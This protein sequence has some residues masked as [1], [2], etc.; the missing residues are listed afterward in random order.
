MTY[1]ECCPACRS[2]DLEVMLDMGEQPMSLVSLQED[3]M[4]SW[5]LER[6]RIRLAIC[7]NCSHVHNIDFNPNYVSYSAAGC[8]MF[9]NGAGWQQHVEDVR[10]IIKNLP[11]INAIV[12]IGAGDCEFLASLETEAA[13]IAV[14]PCEAV[15]RAEELGITRWH[16][17]HFDPSVHIPMDGNIV[18]LMR[19]LLEHMEDPRSFVEKIVRVAEKR[20]G[21]TYLM[22]ECPCC[23]EALKQLRIED[24]TYE[25]PQHFTV[26]SMMYMLRA[27]GI[28]ICQATTHYDME[29]LIGL[30]KIEPKKVHSPTT[31]Q[32]LFGYKRLE[33]NIAKESEWVRLMDERVALWG[34]AGKSAMFI[35]KFDLLETVRVVDSHEEKWGF[36]VPGTKI[37]MESPA[38]LIEDPVDCII[39]TTSWRA[40]DIR[41]EI[42]GSGIPCKHLMKFERGKL[43]EVP[44]EE[45]TN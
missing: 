34:G 1:I 17:E 44:L 12:E 9:N 41:E 30:A 6:H 21:N 33:K 37:V 13:T 15:E 38:T 36:C 14:D 42:L 10:G 7:R 2:T 35:N 31:E 40:N 20:T 26:I 27:C 32:I 23:Q 5:A 45:T 43:V 19:H 24:W 8:R 25:H 3:P 11:E 16:R 22:M 18:I 28:K 4:N 39:V 29:V